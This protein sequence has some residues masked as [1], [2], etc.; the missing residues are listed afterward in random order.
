MSKNKS[1]AKEEMIE[2][3]RADPTGK[4]GGKEGIETLPLKFPAKYLKGYLRAY[5]LAKK[6]GAP[7]DLTAEDLYALAMKEGRFDFG[8]NKYNTNDPESVA[9]YQKTYKDLIAQG[10][11]PAGA[12]QQAMFPAA[13]YDHHKRSQKLGISFGHSWTGTGTSAATGIS[14]KTAGEM[15]NQQYSGWDHPKNKKFID[16]IRKYAGISEPKPQKKAE[17]Q[18]VLPEIDQTLSDL[19][20]VR[21]KEQEPVT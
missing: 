21:A 16:F 11:D 13:L 14:G 1:A 6:H 8:T 4:Y 20:T 12:A 7:K 19:Q 17:L 2:A 9:I 18:D 5:N 3:Y 15:M 10:E